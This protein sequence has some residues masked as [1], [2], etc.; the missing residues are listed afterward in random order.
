MLGPSLLCR[1]KKVRDLFD[2]RD[3][4]D[5]TVIVSFVF[6]ILFMFMIGL[7]TDIPYMKRNFRQASVIACGGLIACSAFGAAITIFVI[8]MLIIKEHEFIFAHMIMII[9]ASS[10]PPVVIRLINELKFD[11][12]DVGRLAISSSLIN[13][14]S[15]MIWY[16][17]VIAFTSG[18]MFGNGMVCLFFTLVA[19]ILNRFLVIWYNGRRQ[20]LM[21][22]PGTDVLTILSP[23]IFFSFLIEEFG[24]NSTISCFFMGVMFPREGKTTRTLLHKLTYSV[25]NFILPIYFGFNGFRFDISYLGSFRNLIVVVLVTVLSIAGKI[26]GTLAACHYLKIP[27]NEAVILAFILNLKG[28]GELLLIDVVPKSNAFVSIS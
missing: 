21:Y 26:I 18:K 15:C 19:T 11:T 24:Y 4:S 27:R 12:A 10:A 1:I 6:R 9:L 16:D 25:N 22:L 5:Y 28:H 2:Q 23:T 20:D 14:M 7:E 3:F 17:I 13:E 8:R